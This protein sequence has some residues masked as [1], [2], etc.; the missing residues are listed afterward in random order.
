MT[1]L[2]DP[3]PPWCVWF[4]IE[5]SEFLMS[6]WGEK[7]STRSAAADDSLGRIHAVH[8]RLRLVWDPE[9]NLSSELHAA[10]TMIRSLADRVGPVPR[11]SIVP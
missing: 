4:V 7:S 5:C 9:Q 10:A 2:V 8:K 6:S 1:G 3:A 11:G